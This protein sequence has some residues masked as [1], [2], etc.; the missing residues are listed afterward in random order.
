M[1]FWPS[2]P[3]TQLKVAPYS[4]LKSENW[5]VK[6][7]QISKKNETKVMRRMITF[8]GQLFKNQKAISII[9]D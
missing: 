2:K 1:Q 9:Q 4:F 8:R 5:K 3:E 6:K 7:M